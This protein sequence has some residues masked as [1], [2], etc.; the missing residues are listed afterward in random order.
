VLV[1]YDEHD[2]AG[3]EAHLTDALTRLT[4]DTGLAARMG[5]AGRRRAVS[6]FGWAGVASRTVEIYRGTI[7]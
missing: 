5:Q 1:H 3:Y 4:T 7:A 2:I 6:E